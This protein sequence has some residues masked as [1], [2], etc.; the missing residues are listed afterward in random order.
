MKYAEPKGYFN[1]AMRETAKKEA[2]K[3]SKSSKGTAKSS[4]V[5]KK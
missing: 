1:K 2:A 4:G 3:S 5:K